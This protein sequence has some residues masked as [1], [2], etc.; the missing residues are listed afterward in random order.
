MPAFKSSSTAPIV[1]MTLVYRLLVARMCNMVYIPQQ[2]CG[3]LSQAD[4]RSIQEHESTLACLLSC[5]Q[6]MARSSF[7]SEECKNSYL[8]KSSPT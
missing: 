4:V 1:K 8:A 6:G 7:D 2:V 5:I 3:F